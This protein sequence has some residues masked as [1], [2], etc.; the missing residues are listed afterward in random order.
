VNI[1]T[2]GLILTVALIVSGTGYIFNQ[3]ATP[4]SRPRPGGPVR[5]TVKHII[6][7][8]AIQTKLFDPEETTY[9]QLT[10]RIPPKRGRGEGTKVVVLVESK[11]VL[12]LRTEDVIEY[13][14]RLSYVE[15]D[16]MPVITGI[17]YRGT[18]R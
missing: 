7:E 3:M 9:D 10:I 5:G 6:T 12:G 8:A 1:V 16:V 2:L 18:G 11:L 17:L 4:T 15:N 13:Y 14:F